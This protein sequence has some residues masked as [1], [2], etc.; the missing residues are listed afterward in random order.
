LAETVVSG[1][2]ADEMGSRLRVQCVTNDPTG[3]CSLVTDYLLFAIGREPQTDFLSEHVK[4]QAPALIESG[5]L[6]F[7]GDVHNGPFRQTAIAVGDGLRAAMQ[8]YEQM[9]L[10]G[11]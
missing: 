1:V 2:E 9:S 10:R 4:M 6:Y 11:A 3:H 7:V 8:I 5:K